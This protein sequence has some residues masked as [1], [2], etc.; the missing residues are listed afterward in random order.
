MH[1]E[2]CSIQ[3]NDLKCYLHALGRVFRSFGEADPFPLVAGRAAARDLVLDT[4]IGGMSEDG[5]L[6]NRRWDNVS[7]APGSAMSV[8]RCQPAL[9]AAS[10]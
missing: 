6:A 3:I 8:R 4:V 10:C 9:K 5:R 2:H 1:A 7:D